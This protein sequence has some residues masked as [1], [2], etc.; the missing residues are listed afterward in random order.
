M[1]AVDACIAITRHLKSI[2]ALPFSLAVFLAAQWVPKNVHV[3][4]EE[5]KKSNV[6][7]W[8]RSSNRHSWTIVHAM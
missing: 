5:A 2:K 8:F 3:Q 4:F 6:R 7:G 1:E